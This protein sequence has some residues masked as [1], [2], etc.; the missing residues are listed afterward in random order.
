MEYPFDLISFVRNKTFS[1][2][3]RFG[4]KT[5][6]DDKPL[7]VFNN[8]SR[9]VFTL[10]GDQASGRKVATCNVHI[11]DLAEIIAN[12]DFAYNKHMSVKNEQSSMGGT[13]P[14]YTKRFN[15]GALKGKTPIDVLLENQ[16][17]KKK[18]EDQ[19]N[20][21]KEN[22]SKYP[23]NQELMDAITEAL[24]ID[25]SQMEKKTVNVAPVEILNIGMRPLIRKKREDGKCFVYECKITWDAT[26][27]YPVNVF[28]DN[29]YAPVD[30]TSQGLLNVK[31]SE[32][33]TVTEVK[34]DFNMTASEWLSAVRAMKM[35][36]EAF[37]YMNFG[38]ALKLAEA[39]DKENRAKASGNTSAAVPKET[40][41]AEEKPAAQ[42][43]APAQNSDELICYIPNGEIKSKGD[44]SWVGILEPSTKNV[45]GVLYVKGNDTR[46]LT[47]TTPL[48]IMAE[49]KGTNYLFKSFA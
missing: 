38:A 26:K 45:I 10:I 33:D 31:V 11:S 13:T 20:W 32:K 29:Y 6:D 48:K 22:L 21:L 27:D 4:M 34:N 1:I 19:F 41:K 28:I 5:K 16:D 12:T 49:R 39:G 8:F 9:F 40:P 7:E 17:G 42:P 37:Y 23:K 30:Q 24:T 25:T 47:A 2:E 14:A 15:T 43:E 3:P 44:T 36:Q 46:C 18:L 35:A